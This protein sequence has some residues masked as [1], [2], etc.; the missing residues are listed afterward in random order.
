MRESIFS[1]DGVEL[2]VNVIKLERGFSV[3]DTE[4]SGRTQDFSMHRDVAG[5]FYNYTLEVEPEPEHRADYDTFYNIISAPV[6][7]H[8][9]VFPHNQETLEFKA[10]VT[11][12]KDSLKRISGKNLWSGLSVYFVAME[13]QR[14]P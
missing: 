7:S 9:M 12:G 11:Q 1:I 2:R 13:P 6:E 4:N 3:T 10:Y 14:R 5:T 8:R